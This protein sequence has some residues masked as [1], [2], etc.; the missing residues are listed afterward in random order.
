MISEHATRREL[1]KRLGGRVGLAGL[2]LA[3]P[4]ALSAQISDWRIRPPQESV[5]VAIAQ[6]RKSGQRRPNVIVLM[7]DQ[8]SPFMCGC[9]GHRSVKSPTI[10]SLAAN[11]AVFDA[12]YCAIPICAPCR[13]A[14]MAGRD[15]STLETWDN[16]SPFRSDWPTFA[17]SFRAA[18]YRT[19][20]CGK[21][22]FVGPDQLHGFEERGTQD[23]YPAD[24]R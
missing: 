10:D 2:G 7:A 12:A 15:T 6:S 19:I 5:D 23:I 13:A 8:L 18:G 22:H 16:A 21:M 1:L 9:Y 11:G 24:F 3:F 14:M 20:L 4:R 17:H